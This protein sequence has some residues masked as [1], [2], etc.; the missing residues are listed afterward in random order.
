MLLA[1]ALTSGSLELVGPDSGGTSSEITIP[2]EPA[3]GLDEVIWCS[4]DCFAHWVA[5]KVAEWRED[6]RIREFPEVGHGAD[7]AAVRRAQ[8]EAGEDADAE[9]ERAAAPAA[10]GAAVA[11]GSVGE[12]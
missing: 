2:I 4:A 1:C 6:L 10:D 9:A 3:T 11:P 12:L 5:E 7:E 8:P